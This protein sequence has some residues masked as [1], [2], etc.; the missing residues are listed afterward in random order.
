MAICLGAGTGMR[1]IRTRPGLFICEKLPPRWIVARTIEAGLVL[2]D[3]NN[4]EVTI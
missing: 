2:C 1:E 3:I 4:T